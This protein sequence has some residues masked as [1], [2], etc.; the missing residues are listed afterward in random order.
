MKTTLFAL[1]LLGLQL[2]GSPQVT[3]AEE[4]HVALI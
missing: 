1:A 2:L 3:A 4:E